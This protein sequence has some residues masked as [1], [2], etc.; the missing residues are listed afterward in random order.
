MERRQR[1]ADRLA[2]IEARIR[3][4][5]PAGE[6]LVAQA[7]GLLAGRVGCRVDEAESHLLWTWATC[8]CSTP[9]A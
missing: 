4:A 5:R 6:V 7:S 2:D 3:A 8:W 9:T 1:Y